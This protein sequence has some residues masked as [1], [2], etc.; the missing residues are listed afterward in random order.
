MDDSYSRH[1][2]PPK[3]NFEVLQ[4]VLQKRRDMTLDV[5]TSG[6]LAASLDEC[7]VSLAG[8][9]L[10]ATFRRELTQISQFRRIPLSPLSTLSFESWRHVVCFPPSTSVLARS[11]L[12]NSRI[13]VSPLRSTL[14]S[15]PQ[16]DDTP[17]FSF[18]DNSQLRFLV[19][20][21]MQDFRLVRG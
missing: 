16:S 19:N 8:C 4:D 2:P 9:T 5:S 13:T 21:Y 17:M 3:T 12:L 10:S 18:T 15:P 7:V 1:A 14:T 20:L 11:Q 6:A